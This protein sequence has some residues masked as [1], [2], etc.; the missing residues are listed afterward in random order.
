MTQDYYHGTIFRFPLRAA[1]TKTILKTSGRDVDSGAVRKLMDSYFDEARV[2]LLF[3]REIKLID[4]SI[5][6]EL[7]SGWS[8]TRS[9][10]ANEFSQTVTCS[11]SKNGKTGED[12]WRVCIQD[13]VLEA[14]R[15]PKSSKRAMK[16]VECGLAALLSSDPVE[17]HEVL[18]SLK[19]LQPRMFNTL[20]LPLASDLPIH[21]HATFLLSGDRQSISIDE[22]GAHAQEAIWNRYL[23]QEALPK[24]YLALLEDVG[25]KV[26]QEVF[27]FWPQEQPPKRSCAELLHDSFWGLLP[28]SSRRVF[29]EAQLA[30]TLPRG[31]QPNKQLF[32]VNQAVLDLLPKAES[33]SLA[34]LLV[35][36]GVNL[37]R[38]IPPGVA[39]HLKAVSG[40]K[41]VDGALF[42]QLLKLKIAKACLLQE[43]TKKCVIWETL[44]SRAMPKQGDLEELD[45]C[46]LLPL[47]G[48]RIAKLTY[49]A[50]AEDSLV[51]KYYVVNEKEMELFGFASEILIPSEFGLKLGPILESGKFDIAM[52]KLS[53]VKKLLKLRPAATNS[54]PDAHTTA[55]LTEFWKFWNSRIDNA[56]EISDLDAKIF[57]AKRNGIE[58]YASPLDFFRL[59][60]VVD[61][62]DVSHQELCDNIPGL[63]RF[64]PNFMPKPLAD[65][66]KNFHKEESFYKFIHALEML[67]GKNTLGSFVQSHL[68]DCHLEVS[69]KSQILKE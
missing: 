23:L 7:E 30:A 54:S 42:R 52:L 50:T 29:P 60:A 21:V 41:T 31:R 32:D 53:H 13:L 19:P 28:T 15:L 9:G 16:N 43:M 63:Y 55:W 1:R 56:L 44:L 64:D 12:K 61:P 3:L 57:R 26:G 40:V 33:E 4:F 67:A 10:Q 39:R 45:D 11:F 37:V 22:N 17:N 46:Y 36:L 5:Q 25:Q 27:N 59:P 6:G 69:W 20:P 68:N 58:K 51:A 24:L 47:A 66:Q 34:P 38:H 49:I 35:S 14:D 65:G 18:D 8:V 2:S 62:S 48:T